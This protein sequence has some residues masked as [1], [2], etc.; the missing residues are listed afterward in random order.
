MPP[1]DF[2]EL[3]AEFL[4]LESELDLLN[5]TIDGVYFWE[6]LRFSVHKEIGTKTGL[7]DATPIDESTGS[8]YLSG[9]WLLARNVLV[10]N[11]FFASEAEL[12]FY[13]KGRRKRLEDRRWW[14]I[15]VDPVVETVNHSST[16]LE[17]PYNVSHY[18]PAKTDSLRY[19]DLIQYAGTFLETVGI[20]RVPIS[21]SERG[22]LK[23]I[24]SKIATRFDVDISLTGRVHSDL[25]HRQVRLPLYRLLIR[26][27]S[28]KLAFLTASYGGRET[29]VEACQ[30]E[31]VPTVELQHGV[32]TR[33]HM[34]YSFPNTQKHVFPDYF[35][36][37]GEYWADSV[38][39]PL[40]NEKVIPV[41]YPYLE[42]RLAKYA[43][44][45]AE[46]RILIISQRRASEQ[47]STFA[48]Q[49]G[50]SEAI[51]SDVVYKLH[52][53]EYDAWPSAYPQLVD[54][55]VTVVQNDP[56]LYELFATSTTQVGVNSTALF[57][58]LNFDLDTF[59]L[60]A[61]GSEY[62]EYLVENE[63]AATVSTAEEFINAYRA[64]IEFDTI[65]EA[66]FFEPDALAN[67][68]AAVMRLFD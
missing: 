61:P 18:R 57:E 24:E 5:Q 26:R 42:R 38:E 43:D 21:D 33:Y 15:Y 4:K 51:K 41:G 48:L 34:A 68:E 6:R 12:L 9:I 55:N 54:S 28:P 47:L 58:G 66:Y 27:V 56:P 40:P 44:C 13:G 3:H 17:R 8:E 2:S 59:V 10:R 60:D 25:A 20:S 1:T 14:D 45:S 63:F 16:C 50:E 11:P 22:L 31:G 29:F 39:L 64:G 67:F 19:T 65:D 7:I 37:F 49:L 30:A 46:K 62:M 36:S 52:P 32:I 35:F 23:K 53:D